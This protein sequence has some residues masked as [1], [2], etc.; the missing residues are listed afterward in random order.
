M[1]AGTEVNGKFYIF[2]G[3]NE[4]GRHS[5][6]EI[7]DINGGVTHG[8]NMPSVVYGPCAVTLPDIEK[9]LIIGG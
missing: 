8:A 5:S 7:I 2:G 3:F 1:A 9:I 4:N 6:V